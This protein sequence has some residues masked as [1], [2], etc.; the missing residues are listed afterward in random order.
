MAEKS[1]YSRLKRIFSNNVIVRRIGK[2]QIKVFDNDKLQSSGN[3]NV[4]RYIDRFTRLHGVKSQLSTYN[5]N[6]NYY[7]SKTELYTD[8]EVMDQ[9]SII[10]SALDIYADEVVMKDEFGQILTIR[11]DDDRIQK[12]LEN[13][14]FD[15]LNVDFNLWPWVRNMCKYGD[16]YLKLDIEETIGIVNVTPMSSYEMVREE[17]LDPRNPYLVQFS[18]FN[19]KGVKWENYE[20]AHFRLI[21]DSNFLPYGKSALEGARKVWKQL[22]LMEDAMLIHRIMRAPERRVFKIDI[23]NIPPNEVDGYMQKVINQM[24][25]TPFID[26]KTGEYNLKFNLQNMLEDY[27]LPQRGQQSGTAIE[28]LNGMEFTGIDDIEYLRNRMMAGL[29]IPKSFLGYEEGLCIAPDTLIPLISGEEKTVLQ[30]IEDYE[31]GIKNYVYSIDEDTKLIVPGEIDWAGFTRMNAKIVRVHLDNGKYIDCT[32]DHN[33]LTRDGEWIEAQN[34]ISGQ[35]LMPLYTRKSTEKNI[36]G[37]TEV[38]HPGTGNWEMVHRL[39][40]NHYGI[41]QRGNVIHHIA[42]T[43]KGFMNN[44]KGE[45]ANHKVTNVEFLAEQIDTCDLTIS[46]YHN[47]ATAAGVI[48]HNSGKATLAAEDVRFAR[49]IERLQRIVI[50]ELTKI[51]IIHLYAQ[52]FEGIDIMNF[53]ITMTSPSAIYEQEKIT[54]WNSKVDLAKSIQEGQLMSLDWVYKNIFNF[55]DSEI[56]TEKQEIIEDV[57]QKYR[58]TKIENDGEDPANEKGFLPITAEEPEK[59]GED[60]EEGGEEEGSNPFEAGGKEENG[61]KEKTTEE[62]VEVPKG[63]WPGAGRPK[64]SVK[65]GTNRYVHGRDPLGYEAWQNAQKDNLKGKSRMENTDVSKMYG[66][67]KLKSVKTK[68]ITET[69]DSGSFLDEKSI[70]DQEL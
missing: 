33:F 18:N 8:Y 64:E 40:A 51:A 63:G 46:K 70:I 15:I 48:I 39:I 19:Y 30:L 62:G 2:D 38:Y 65:Y 23:G 1:L 53:E 55:S 60:G 58:K 43:N 57:K 61:S 49:T 11:S 9:D 25:K 68:V 34:L 37:Y 56:E 32:P 50:S 5:N 26:D 31:N 69:K 27:Y 21:S 24:K 20:I 45:Y 28:T 10:N 13:L 52:G 47:F 16:F 4:S 29:K 66:L 41:K 67:S 14:F 35:A 44:F 17:G 36:T 12:I 6:Y 54:L 59:G 22:T 3:L 42:K 7:S